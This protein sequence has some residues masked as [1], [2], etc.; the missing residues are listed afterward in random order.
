MKTNYKSIH[1]QTCPAKIKIKI[2]DLAACIVDT[3]KAL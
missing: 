1:R 3:K 2:K